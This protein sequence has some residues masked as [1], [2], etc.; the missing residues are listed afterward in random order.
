MEIECPECKKINFVYFDRLPD[1]VCDDV[2]F[3]CVYCEYCF[4]IGWYATVEL[5]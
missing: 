5:R 3:E 1:N 4:R 2:D